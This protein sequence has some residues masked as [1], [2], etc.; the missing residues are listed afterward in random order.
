MCKAP[1]TCAVLQRGMVVLVQ[2]LVLVV[3]LVVTQ[4]RRLLMGQW[5]WHLCAVAR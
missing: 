5:G 4:L 3:V 1:S 2:V